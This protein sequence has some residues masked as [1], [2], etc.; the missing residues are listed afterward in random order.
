MKHRM[1]SHD[2]ALRFPAN[3]GS[4][5]A[6]SAAGRTLE[7]LRARIIALDL[8]PDTVLSRTE[9]AR[10]YDISQTPLRDALLKLEAEGLVQIFPQSRTLVTRIDTASIREAVFLRR[11]IEMEVVRELAERIEEPTLSRLRGILAMQG[12]LRREKGQIGAFQELDESFHLTMIAA[13]GFHGL[14]ELIR[15][16]S[17]HLNRLRRLDMWDEAK[18]S[19]ILQDHEDIIDALEARDPGAAVAATRRHLSQT[20]ARIN[21]LRDRHPEYFRG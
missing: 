21:L 17:G 13:V 11:S 7:S 2:A 18:I 12:A 4:A 5:A 8:P 16:R 20:I 15:A 6:S 1:S 3:G 19:G 10:E 14:H 9:L